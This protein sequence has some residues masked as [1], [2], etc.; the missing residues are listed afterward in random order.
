MDESAQVK[1]IFFDFDGVI[2]VEKKGTPTM[3]AYISE[4]TGLPYDRVET[5]YR[6]FNKDLLMGNIT[7]KDMWEPFCRAVGQ[8]IDY[9]IL[10]R[11]FL[12][13]TLD[14]QIIN[15]IREYRKKYLIGMITDNKTDRIEAVIE[16]TELKGLFDAVIISA[17][18]HAQK[19][20][21]K[22]FLEALKESGLR[23]D[24]CVFID[25]SAA[26]LVVPEKMGFRT[27][28]FDD[29]KRDYTELLKF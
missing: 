1:G 8:D 3:V 23:A 10:E 14:R 6:K 7:H 11:S 4:K 18:V 21:E 5:E 28:F 25:N 9:E 27:I 19:T 26:N 20:E 24:E 16:N 13:M 17:N 15:L 2:T 29:A 12:N 22:I